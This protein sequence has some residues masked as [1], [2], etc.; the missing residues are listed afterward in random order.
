MEDYQVI[1]LVASLIQGGQYH[2]YEEDVRNYNDL[3]REA[4]KLVAAAKNYCDRKD[5]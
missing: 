3:V 5:T 4:G 2:L 1:A